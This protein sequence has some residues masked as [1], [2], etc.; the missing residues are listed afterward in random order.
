M[1]AS[2]VKGPD[3]QQPQSFAD[4]VFPHQPAQLGDQLGGPAARQVRLG[5]ELRGVKPEFIRP[6]CLGAD[7]R[8]R[9]DVGEQ[10]AAPQRERLRE[11]TGGALRFGRG[12][13]APA[14]RDQP[15]ELLQVHVP[16]GDAEQ[17]PGR[18]VHEQPPLGV[19]DQP[20][21]P[22][23]VDADQVVRLRGRAVAP[24]LQDQALRRDE[25]PGPHQQASQKR[26]P[27]R[28]ADG[29]PAFLVRPDL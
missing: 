2:L 19:A 23:H 21:Q 9:R 27:L 8:G 4:R 28:G 26:A 1:P 24:Q 11:E 3:E 25:L 29:C 10:P 12:E 7:E 14:I 5:V 16:W 18:P 6:L 13:R 20:P 15:L 22:V 17:V